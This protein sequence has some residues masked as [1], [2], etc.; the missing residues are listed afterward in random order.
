MFLIQV[1]CKG[2]IDL[3]RFIFSSDFFYLDSS[4]HLHKTLFIYL[5]GLLILS[6]INEAWRDKSTRQWSNID[7]LLKKNKNKTTTQ[8]GF[9]MLHTKRNTFT[10]LAQPYAFFFSF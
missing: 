4:K 1:K 2:F 6:R 7:Q 10:L 8:K 5:V 3:L 9:F